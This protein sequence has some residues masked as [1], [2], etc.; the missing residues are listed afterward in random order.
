MVLLFFFSSLL[1]VSV[2]SWVEVH[3]WET[4][5]FMQLHI[6]VEACVSQANSKY[7]LDLSDPTLKS[8]TLNRFLDKGFL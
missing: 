2:S 6:Y 3:M 8:P 1:L 7:K 4:H 5:A